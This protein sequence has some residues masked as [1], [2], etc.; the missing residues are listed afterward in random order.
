[1]LN[2]SILLQLCKSLFS[3]NSITADI[4]MLCSYKK[5]KKKV[6]IKFFSYNFISGRCFLHK[7]KKKKRLVCFLKIPN[8]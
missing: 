5:K 8:V 2:L 6:L 3:M 7:K 1:M 4:I